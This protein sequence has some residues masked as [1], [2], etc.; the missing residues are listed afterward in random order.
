MRD[1][2][3]RHVR[4]RIA[5]TQALLN[6]DLWMKCFRAFHTANQTTTNAVE[7]YHNFLK[8]MNLDVKARQVHTLRRACT[9]FLADMRG[10]RASALRS[11]A[12][13]NNM[14]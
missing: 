8:H 1:V 2:C 4:S 12:T 9:A 14:T 13:S 5:L 10:T 3:G 7:A 11:A 6:A